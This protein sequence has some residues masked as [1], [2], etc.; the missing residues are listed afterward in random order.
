M[1]RLI[2]IAKVNAAYCVHSCTCVR[3]TRLVMIASTRAAVIVLGVLI[4]IVFNWLLASVLANI[5]PKL[6]LVSMSC[7][8]FMSI[9]CTNS[10]PNFCHVM[11]LS[12]CALCGARCWL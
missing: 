2:T 3:P 10:V 7:V 8:P 12:C 4:V 6:S 1:P 9:V 5:V 11:L